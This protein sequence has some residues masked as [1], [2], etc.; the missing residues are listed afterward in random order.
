MLFKKTASVPVAFEPVR[1][2]DSS[3]DC[4]CY[5]WVH[6]DEEIWRNDTAKMHDDA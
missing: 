3:A 2:I 5:S 6:M 4:Q 1:K